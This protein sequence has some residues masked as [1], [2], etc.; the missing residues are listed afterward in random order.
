MVQYAINM[1]Q[2]KNVGLYREESEQRAERAHKIKDN[3]QLNLL[4]TIWRV[5][6]EP[7][8]LIPC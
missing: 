7:V 4:C 8:N 1:M 6:L 2:W 3:E 5:T